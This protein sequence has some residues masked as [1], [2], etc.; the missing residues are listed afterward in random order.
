MSIIGRYLEIL[1]EYRKNKWIGVSENAVFEEDHRFPGMLSTNGY[2]TIKHVVDGQIPINFGI[3]VMGFHVDP[4]QQLKH[5]DHI[6]KFMNG[7]LS[8]EGQRSLAS[9]EQLRSIVHHS[10]A[11]IV[12][13]TSI[14]DF[15]GVRSARDPSKAKP[16]PFISATGAPLVSLRGLRSVRVKRIEI[17]YEPDLPLMD[18]MEVQD[19]DSVILMEPG[20]SV[21]PGY[22][23]MSDMGGPGKKVAEILGEHMAKY[24]TDPGRAMLACQDALVDAGFPGN[25]RFG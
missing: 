12:N 10:G 4:S 9:F 5:F 6:P 11:L 16:K 22:A 19:L 23:T 2:V 14:R 3:A 8:L 18:L 1:E 7:P 25:A 24:Q 13:N 17:T 20:A 15:N 21:H